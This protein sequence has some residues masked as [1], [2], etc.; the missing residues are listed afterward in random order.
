MLLSDSP[1]RKG[2]ATAQAGNSGDG[3]SSKRLGNN[4]G[5]ELNA[6][7]SK[8]LDL[9]EEVDRDREEQRRLLEG[10]WGERRGLWRDRR[11]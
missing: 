10:S 7:P 2:T 8:S 1:L 11:K 4:G 3:D 6:T 9:F 5:G